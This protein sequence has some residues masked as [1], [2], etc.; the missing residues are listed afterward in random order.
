MAIEQAAHFTVLPRTYYVSEEI[1]AREVEQI[2]NRQWK[3]ATHTSQIPNAGDF[4]VEDVVGESVI[5]VRGDDGVVNAFFNVCRH[6][7]YQFCEQP[8]GSVKRFVCPYH[9]W[10]FGRDGCVL[11]VPGAPTANSST[12]PIGDFTARM[13]R[14]GTG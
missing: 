3:F 14:S 11:H 8:C 12:T 9:Q 1:F 10:S 5:I 4:V 7:G 13:S 6:R 2:F